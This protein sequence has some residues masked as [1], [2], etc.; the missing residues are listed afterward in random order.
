MRKLWFVAAAAAAVLTASTATAVTHAQTQGNDGQA[1]QETTETVAAQALTLP[2]GDVVRQWPS[3]ALEAIPAEGRE[4]VGFIGKTATDGS[5]DVVVFPADMAADLQSG[6][7]DIRR[8]NVS[9]LLEDGHTDAAAVSESELDDRPYEALAP[10]REAES[11][12]AATRTILVNVL[13]RSGDAPENALLEW[14]QVDGDKHGS[15]PIGDSG[16]GSVKLPSG[17]YLISSLIWNAA[18]DTERGEATFGY[19]ALTVKD[20]ASEL[21]IDAAAAQPIGVDVEREDAEVTEFVVVADAENEHTR[22]GIFEWF[23]GG[24][25]AYLMPKPRVKGFEYEFLYQPE[26]KGGGDEPYTYHLAFGQFGAYPTETRFSVA[27]AELAVERTSYQ[28]WG[29][30]LTGRLCDYPLLNEAQGAEFCISEEIAVPSEHTMLYSTE[31]VQWTR[32]LKV[33]ETENYD[34]VDGYYKRDEGLAFEPGETERV[35]GGDAM[36]T[37]VPNLDRF[38]IDD[39]QHELSGNT[40]SAGSPDG[41]LT[42]VGY[43]GSATLS[44]NGETIG[45]YPDPYVWG[46]GIPAD[47]GGRYSVDVTAE[48]DSATNPLATKSDMHWEFRSRPSEA[49]VTLPVV[50][51]DPEGVEYGEA[52]ATVP[53]AVTLTLASFGDAPDTTA[54]AM[55]FEVSY[56]DG[57][58]WAE[59]PIALDGDTAA[60][61]LEHPE[62]AEFVST[63]LTAVDDAGTEVSHTVIRSWGLK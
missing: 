56:D 8:Y 41:A 47:Q 1:E 53:Q 12:A 2:T 36:V 54:T 14:T 25:D 13:D 5:G 4:H 28:D 62:D 50:V 38:E 7:E 24:T 48:R 26:L 29:T 9:A 19:T 42:W 43:T 18:T 15:I 23:D 17:K 59:I 60:A 10:A 22:S 40:V 58:T 21:V 34:L 35:L 6:A 57:A 32:D 49:A 30:D 52:D 37:G 3:G 51:V 33:G 16:T 46:F 61:S 45:T 63:R 11:E 20:A 44:K 39:E 27:D 31:G 55:T